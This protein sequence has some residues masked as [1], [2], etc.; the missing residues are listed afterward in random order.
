MNSAIS[1][2]IWRYFRLYYN[3]DAN[4]SDLAAL[5]AADPCCGGM[6]WKGQKLF[7]REKKWQKAF[8]KQT[9]NFQNGQASFSLVHRLGNCDRCCS[10]YTFISIKQRIG[11][12]W[13][14]VLFSPLP[15][16][17]Q[18]NGFSL[19]SDIQED[20]Q[21]SPT[22]SEYNFCINLINEASFLDSQHNKLS[23][24]LSRFINSCC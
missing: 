23:F 4:A 2:E 1:V 3:D 12:F 7:Y 14:L 16:L 5:T 13:Q 17:T 18:V 8:I 9:Q 19:S 10:K 22:L 15:P 6:I 11:S 21:N 24:A 20:L